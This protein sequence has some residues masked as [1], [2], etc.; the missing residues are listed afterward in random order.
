LASL[1]VLSFFKKLSTSDFT[2]AFSSASVISEASFLGMIACFS[3]KDFF[4][5]SGAADILYCVASLFFR[6]GATCGGDGAAG[7]G[8]GAR[9]GDVGARGGGVGAVGGSVGA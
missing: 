4:F 2:E 3:S 1:S 8:V 6:V 9:G 5:G 7:G